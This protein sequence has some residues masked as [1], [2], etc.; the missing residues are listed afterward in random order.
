MPDEVAER[1]AQRLA[2]PAQVAR[3]RLFPM[4]FL[5]AYKA[6]PSLRWSGLGSRHTF[7]GLSDKAFRLVPL[8]EAGQDARWD[9]LFSQAA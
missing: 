7:G 1:V 3:S 6:A 4:R 2:D 8:L 5:A 9:D